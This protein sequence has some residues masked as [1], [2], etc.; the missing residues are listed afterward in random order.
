MFGNTTYILI[1][2]L[3]SGIQI[4]QFDRSSLIK[5]LNCCFTDQQ[6]RFLDRI[7]SDIDYLEFGDV[8]VIYGEFVFPLPVSIAKEY[9]L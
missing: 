9:T 8:I 4:K 2:R 1:Y 7:P 3:E 6:V 5:Y